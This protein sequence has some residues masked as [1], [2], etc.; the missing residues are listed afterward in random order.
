MCINEG[1]VESNGHRLAFLA[2]NEQL[3]KENNDPVIVFIHGVLASLRFW[4]DFVPKSF[5]KSVVWYSLSLP[6]HYPSQVPQDFQEGQVHDDWFF[7]VMNDAIKKLVGKK[8]VIVVGHSTGGFCALNLAIHKAP[9]VAA[10]ISVAGFHNGQWGGAEGLLVRLAGMGSWTKPIFVANLAIAQQ[11]SF[12]RRLFA[13]SL[14]KDIL[15]SLSNPLNDQM[16]TNIQPD[17]S[18]Q[19]YA[20]LFPLFHGINN[21]EIANK[22][23]EI[24]IPCF[25]FAGTHDPIVLLAQSRLLSTEIPNAKTVIFEAVGHMPFIEANDRYLIELE[26]ALA[27]IQETLRNQKG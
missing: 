25:I 23:K 11:L 17:T 24:R 3:Q 12:L 5:K 15:A 6:A 1:F 27:E 19:D 16:L 7:R 22:L 26:N 8:K 18:K 4:L 9:N 14:T 2:V 21:I 13:G 10:V 20:D